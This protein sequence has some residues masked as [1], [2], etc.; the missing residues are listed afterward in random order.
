MIHGLGQIVKQKNQKN[1]EEWIMETR[2]NQNSEL[3]FGSTDMSFEVA[4]PDFCSIFDAD[5]VKFRNVF[6]SVVK[7]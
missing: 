1:Y 6:E 7:I 3:G 5:D 4:R 2:E